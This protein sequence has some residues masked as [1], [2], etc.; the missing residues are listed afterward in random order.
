M[1]YLEY[2]EYR[3]KYLDLQGQFSHYLT[4]KE[5]IF[6]KALPNAIRYDRERVQCTVD[7]NPL[8]EYA[9]QLDEAHIDENLSRLRQLL[10]DRERLLSM[11]EMELRKSPDKFDRVYV[12]RYLDGHGI[13]RICR[14]MNY[15]RSQVYK[16]LGQIKRRCNKNL[17]KNETK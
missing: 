1:I 9:I 5:E 10:E 12:C 4:Q 17:Q 7:S 8:E 2:E 13:N 11:K 15:S 16:I 3:A 14:S 6:T